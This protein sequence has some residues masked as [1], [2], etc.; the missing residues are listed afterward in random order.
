MARPTKR[1]RSNGSVR[2]KRSKNLYEYRYLVGDI[3]KGGYAKTKAEADD[4]LNRA[5]IMISDGNLSADD[6]KFSEYVSIWLE[7]KKN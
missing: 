2:F 1:R 3:R 4:K 5:L 7:S 6:P